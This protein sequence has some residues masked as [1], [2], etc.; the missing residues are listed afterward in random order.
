MKT[1]FSS[2][3]NTIGFPDDSEIYNNINRTNYEGYISKTIIA[4]IL[5]ISKNILFN[6]DVSYKSK[7]YIQVYI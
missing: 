4:D 5:V 1:F 2:I 3:S 7:L 6:I